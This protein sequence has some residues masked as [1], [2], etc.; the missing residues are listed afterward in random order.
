MSNDTC[1][2]HP[3]RP[4]AVIIHDVTTGE[5]KRTPLCL[6][7]AVEAGEPT[8]LMMKAQSDTMDF[9]LERLS[10]TPLSTERIS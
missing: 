6:D 8:A 9:V 1:Q 2:N 4:C 10:P 7:C 5:H 3:D